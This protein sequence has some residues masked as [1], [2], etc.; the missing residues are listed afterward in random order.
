MPRTQPPR[1]PAKLPPLAVERPRV[2]GLSAAE[3]RMLDSTLKVI[4][5][6]RLAPGAKLAEEE[7]A[8]IFAISRA[9]VR[10]VLLV[11]SQRRVVRLEA[12]RGAFVAR[13]GS[14]E[15]RGALHARRLLEADVARGVA[16]LAKQPRA[17]AVQ[18]LRR[19]LAEETRAIRAHDTVA[20]VRL[21]GEFHTRLAALAGNQVILGI[22]HDLIALTSLALASTP[23][24]SLDCTVNEHIPLVDAIERGDGEAAAR[25]MVGHLDEIEEM[26]DAGNAPAAATLASVFA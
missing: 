25:L 17:A 6:R 18:E 2:A 1:K 19:H 10:K 20:A 7:L 12:N 14:D 8:S 24:H 4:A 22:L 5:E 21:S 15:A 11:L 3:Q 9:R 16:R 23:A 26:L 13:P